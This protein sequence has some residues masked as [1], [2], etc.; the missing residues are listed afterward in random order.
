MVSIAIWQPKP[1]IAYNGKNQPLSWWFYKQAFP[2]DPY[3]CSYHPTFFGMCWYSFF[4]C[5]AFGAIKW[6]L[7]TIYNFILYDA[8]EIWRGYDKNNKEISKKDT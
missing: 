8:K 5:L 3:S 1:H 2:D 6:R 7:K 4:M